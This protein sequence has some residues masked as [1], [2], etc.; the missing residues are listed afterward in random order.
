MPSHFEDIGFLVKE[1]DQYIDLLNYMVKNSSR[2]ETV[3]GEYFL[4]S[5][6]NRIEVWLHF[7]GQGF[8]GLY[9]FF[10]GSSFMK[11]RLAEKFVTEDGNTRI[12][13]GIGL[14]EEDKGGAP[15]IF[16]IPNYWAI[17]SK[18]K[19]GNIYFA[20]ITVFADEVDCYN[21]EKD[22]EMNAPINKEAREKAEKAED[23]TNVVRGY[24]PTYYMPIGTFSVI[25]DEPSP[26][27]PTLMFASKIKKIEKIQNPYTKVCFYYMIV[28]TY[29]GEFNA[30]CAE[31]A[32]TKNPVVGGILEGHFYVTGKIRDK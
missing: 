11:I 7:K 25:L 24:A 19:N 23:R 13:C 30:V 3:E 26:K 1:K 17:E 6:G 8:V 29:Y 5:P 31:T 2:K 28:E 27:Q 4:Y 14:N 18:L 22:F 32:F 9:P 12:E 20:N 15:L 21:D 10:N 16:D